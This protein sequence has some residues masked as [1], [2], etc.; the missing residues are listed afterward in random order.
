MLHQRAALDLPHQ[1]VLGVPL[2]TLVQTRAAEPSVDF[3]DVPPEEWPVTTPTTILQPA[4]V[5]VDPVASLML[6]R[7][8]QLNQ[9][10]TLLRKELSD[11]S[12]EGR[13]RR[14][15]SWCRQQLNR[16]K[17]LIHGR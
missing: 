17:E 16:V 4:P 2:L 6:A 3:R 9:Q 8:D 5:D 12:F 15:W 14:V 1:P 11:R 10:L 13:C 7:L